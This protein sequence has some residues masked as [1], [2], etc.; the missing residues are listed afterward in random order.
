MGINADPRGGGNADIRL[1]KIGNYWALP[2]LGFLSGGT[3]AATA[4]SSADPDTKFLNFYT[5][6]T[7]PSGDAR[8]IYMRLALDGAGTGGG[9]AGRFYTV[10]GAALTGG[11]THGIHATLEL[12][13]A[14]SQSGLSA[15]VRATLAAVAATKTLTGTYAALELES[16]FK[17]GN[18]VDG[19][20]V[21]F[22]RATDLGDVKM[23][24]LFDFSTLVAGDTLSAIQ[25]DSGAVSTIYGYARVLCPGGAVGYIC[26]YAAHS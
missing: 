20:K 5:K 19:Q 7:A 11:G 14:G 24:Y 25:A 22:I 16:D 17:T 9:E 3:S 23:P 2:N 12:A 4:V 6:S 10:L 26:I 15:S 18:T 21:S 8:G 13:A 1:F